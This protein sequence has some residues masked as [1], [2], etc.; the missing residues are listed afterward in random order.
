MTSKMKHFHSEGHFD[1][2]L[3]FCLI[4]RV[5]V[6]LKMVIFSRGGIEMFHVSRFKIPIQICPHR[7][8]DS[9]IWV[10]IQD[11]DLH[12]NLKN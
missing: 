7:F 8:K 5:E 2:I 3:R 4:L 1:K 6:V 9:E 12:L 10:K 11:Q